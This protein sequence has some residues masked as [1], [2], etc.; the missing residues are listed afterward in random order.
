MK[1]LSR[2]RGM[3]TALQKHEST[4]L[5]TR[6]SKFIGFSVC[7]QI[8]QI[9]QIFHLLIFY[10]NLTHYSLSYGIIITS[11]MIGSTGYIFAKRPATENADFAYRNLA[12]IREGLF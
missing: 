12:K 11:I 2:V 7:R 1:I 10:N 8:R 6:P 4:L 5:P 9:R 3:Y